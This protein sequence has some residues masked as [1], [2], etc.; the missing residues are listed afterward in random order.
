MVSPSTKQYADL[1][2]VLQLM[3]VGVIDVK[4]CEPLPDVLV[5]LCEPL[6]SLTIAEVGANS[7]FAGHANATGHYAGHPEQ[8]AALKWEGPK[9]EGP[10]KGL[11]SKYPRTEPEQTFLRG[12]WPTN[13]HG[14]SQ[15]TCEHSLHI[16]QKLVSNLL[17]CSHL[18]GILHRPSNSRARQ[19]SHR[20]GA[21]QQRDLHLEPL[22][23]YRPILRRRRYQLTA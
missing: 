1:T 21:S 13:K 19:G 9:H 17:Y 7:L 16:H 12:A 5:D 2:L 6:A 22:D 11:L 15:F 23:P 8:E 4:T 14:L 10:R 20:V 3:D 18:P